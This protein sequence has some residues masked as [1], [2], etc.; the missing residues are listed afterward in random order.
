MDAVVPGSS[1][2]EDTVLMQ[3]EKVLGESQHTASP[4]SC[5][6]GT[7]FWWLSPGLQRNSVAG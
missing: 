6:R 4:A 3:E 2:T 5:G 7:F 1:D